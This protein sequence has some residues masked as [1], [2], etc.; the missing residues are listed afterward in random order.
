MLVLNVCIIC[1]STVHT[2][3]HLRRWRNSDAECLKSR[4]VDVLDKLSRFMLNAALGI[5][6]RS[7][8]KTANESTHF[9]FR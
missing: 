5:N 7:L 8:Q 1:V 4:T 2:A 6:V 9:S 3:G